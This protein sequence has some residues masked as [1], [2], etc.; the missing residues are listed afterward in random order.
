MEQL[1]ELRP[2]RYASVPNE[3]ADTL[4]DLNSVGLLTL[5]LR[6]A[7]GYPFTVAGVIKQ[8]SKIPGPK[9]GKAAAYGAMN[10][11]IGHRWAC[12]VRF[13][14]AGGHWLTGLFRTYTRFTDDDLREVCRRFKAGASIRV[15][16]KGCSKDPE[17]EIQTVVR[18]GAKLIWS[19]SITAGPQYK[20]GHP[21]TDLMKPGGL[22]STAS[23]PAAESSPSSGI[24]EVGVTCTDDASPQVTPTKEEEEN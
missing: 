19:G 2:H 3:A 22:L 24:P 17:E 23:T 13:M 4:P 10:V 7:P 11:L 1:M 8:K 6:H 15:R 18:P 20:Y 12:R 16:C 14:C 21:I 5:M 9:L